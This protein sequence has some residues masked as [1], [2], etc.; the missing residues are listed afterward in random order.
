MALCRGTASRRSTAPCTWSEML[1]VSSSRSCEYRADIV[2]LYVHDVR[3]QT[4]TSCR[5]MP[6]TFVSPVLVVKPRRA[7]R[8]GRN[9]SHD[10]NGTGARN[11]SEPLET[12]WW[13]EPRCENPMDT[14]SSWTD[15]QP[16]ATSVGASLSIHYLTGAVPASRLATTASH[17][18]SSVMCGKLHSLNYP[19]Y[20][21]QARLII[22]DGHRFGIR[23]RKK[24][25]L[26]PTT[27]RLSAGWVET[28]GSQWINAIQP[29]RTF[30]E[31]LRMGM[32]IC[33]EAM[34][35]M[36]KNRRIGQLAGLSPE[37]SLMLDFPYG[38]LERR[39]YMPTV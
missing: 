5:R 30:G 25:V 21:T 28:Q 7:R 13:V 38:M 8:N 1:L 27:G 31:S 12:S 11:C 26:T 6:S 19:R 37:Q 2:F 20:C 36:Y 34:T 24:S 23:H 3:V 32:P 9:C 29:T 14:K 35:R 39:S 10:A 17:T 16:N 22:L 33:S 4:A 15:G 18:E